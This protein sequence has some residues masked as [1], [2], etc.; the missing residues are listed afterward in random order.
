VRSGSPRKR[1]A[2]VDTYNRRFLH[3]DV[4]VGRFPAMDFKYHKGR[5]FA[6]KILCGDTTSDEEGTIRG[7]TRVV[8]NYCSEK[9][10]NPLERGCYLPKENFRGNSIQG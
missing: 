7:V 6:T 1:E 5:N 8:G 4:M 10:G 2:F 9:S 3:I